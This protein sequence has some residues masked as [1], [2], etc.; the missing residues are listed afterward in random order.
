M[1]DETKTAT[2]TIR[3][4]AKEKRALEKLAVQEERKPSDVLRQ[5]MRKRLREAGVAL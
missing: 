5:A 3:M 1:A 2:V 4:T